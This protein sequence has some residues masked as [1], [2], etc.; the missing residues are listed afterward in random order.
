MPTKV[1]FVVLRQ[2]DNKTPVNLNNVIY[3]LADTFL[4]KPLTR[5]LFLRSTSPRIHGASVCSFKFERRFQN[6]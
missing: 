4:K 5:D 1:A 2:H 6:F 3:I